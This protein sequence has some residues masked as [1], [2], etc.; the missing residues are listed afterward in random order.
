MY[1]E[2]IPVKYSLSRHPYTYFVPEMWQSQVVRGG[3]IEIPVGN[4]IDSGIIAH[5]RDS[6]PETLSV[7]DIKPILGVYASIPLFSPV[8][9]DAMLELARLYCIPVHRILSLFFPTP[10]RSRLDKRNYILEIPPLSATLTCPIQQIHVFSERIFSPQD[11]EEYLT[12]ESVFI[13]PDDMF[14]LQFTKGFRNRDDILILPNDATDVKR[15]QAWI[16]IYEKK[17]SIIF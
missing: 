2:V 6:I 10:L 1:I 4:S 17:Y 11:V 16:D 8:Q 15:S 14:L 7:S 3:Y 5:I 9:L 13:F 12:P